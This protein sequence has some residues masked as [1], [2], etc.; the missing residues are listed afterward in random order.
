MSLCFP[1]VA[2]VKNSAEWYIFAMKLVLAPSVLDA[3]LK[4]SFHFLLARHPLNRATWP[5]CPVMLVVRPVMTM[6]YMSI[7]TIGIIAQ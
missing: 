4:C 5:M 2:A 6:V 1:G 7:E 3:P